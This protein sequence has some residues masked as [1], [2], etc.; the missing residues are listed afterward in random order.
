MFGA[1]QL[2]LARIRISKWNF[3]QTSPHKNS[4]PSPPATLLLFREPPQAPKPASAAGLPRG[5]GTGRP[6]ALCSQHHGF[7]VCVN[8]SPRGLCRASFATHAT[9]CS[10]WRSGAWG[11]T[12]ALRPGPLRRCKRYPKRFHPTARRFFYLARFLGT[13]W[14]CNSVGVR[15]GRPHTHGTQDPRILSPEGIRSTAFRLSDWPEP[16]PRANLKST[17]IFRPI[18]NAR[19]TTT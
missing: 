2:A 17:G 11:V 5:L 12:T 10:R 19:G 4:R 15:A 16:R 1:N 9:L 13:F 3:F 6:S 14:R 18:Y 8:N 7:P